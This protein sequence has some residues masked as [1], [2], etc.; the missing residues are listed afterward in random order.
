MAAPEARGELRVR[1]T[2]CYPPPAVPESRQLWFMLDTG[3]CR[4][5][6]DV[7]AII[8][9]RFYYSRQ[10]ALSLYLDGS[11]LPPGESAR[12]IRDNDSISVKWEDGRPHNSPH[13]TAKKRPRLQEEGEDNRDLKKSR[14][15]RRET[16]PAGEEEE[17]EVRVRAKKDKAEELVRERQKKSTPEEE[18][19]RVQ[20]K[21]EKKT[22]EEKVRVRR[23]ETPEE[24]VRVQRK[25]G[26]ETAEEEVRVQRKKSRLVPEEEF[27]ARRKKGKEI[28]EEEVRAHRKKNRAAPEEEVRARQKKKN[29]MVLEEEVIAQRRNTGDEESDDGRHHTEK[30]EKLSVEGGLTLGTRTRGV[31]TVV[32]EEFSKLS[33]TARSPRQVS[34]RKAAIPVISKDSETT[35]FQPQVWPLSAAPQEAQGSSSSSSDQEDRG[36]IRKAGPP[37]MVQQSNGTLSPPGAYIKK[38]LIPSPMYNGWVGRGTAPLQPAGRGRGTDNL[39]WRG[40]GFRGRGEAQTPNHYF[41]NYSSEATKEQQLHEEANNLSVLI[42]NPP[43]AVSTDYSALP[44]L[45]APPQPG[46]IIAFKLLELTENYTPEVSD[47]KEGRV[48]S[49]DAG[50]QE[51]ELELLSQQKKKEPGKFDL[52]YEGDDG[53]DIVEYAVP[54]ETKITQVWNSLIEPRLVTE[55]GHAALLSQSPSLVAIS[56]APGP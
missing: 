30:R 8:R 7:S 4:A 29:R 2:F 6:T 40:R 13:R 32:G 54:Q 47:Y 39:P 51:L 1:L 28:H 35:K 17:E 36:P 25:K 26:K 48:L 22:A 9:E 45:A 53:T 34:E 37:V 12:V 43:A 27:R 3:Q 11:L 33:D 23:K 15:A 52:I 5:V 56:V 41:Y 16:T 19:V 49:F 24:E 18:E 31:A 50:S 55:A 42:Q 44:L 21:K 14:G 38:P 20:R 46:R 10:G